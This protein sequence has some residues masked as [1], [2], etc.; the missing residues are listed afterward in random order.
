MSVLLA[1]TAAVPEVAR[2]AGL[3]LIQ[4]VTTNPKLMRAVTGDPLRQL[5]ALL[6]LDLMTVYYQPTGVE[7][8]EP[9][10]LEAEAVRA[11]DLGPDRVVIK[12]LATA[13]GTRLA[14]ALVRRHIPVALTGAQSAEAMAVALALGCGGVIPYYD[15]GLRDPRVSDTLI[16][17]LA[18]VRWSRPVPSI[19][20]ASVKTGEQVV[21]AFRQGADGVSAAPAV[22]DALTSHPASVEA[23]RDFLAQYGPA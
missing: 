14:S 2:L 20:T 6:A 4:G 7:G 12:A 8:A 17:D 3:G 18:A 15:R 13:D 19:T 5:A 11:H 23:E 1:D 9:K 10:D 16:A 21:A 22:L